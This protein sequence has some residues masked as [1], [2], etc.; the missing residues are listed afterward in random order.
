[1]GKML[2]GSESGSM[3]ISNEGVLYF[4]FRMKL[5]WWPNFLF[6]YAQLNIKNLFRMKLRESLNF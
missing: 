4:G 6:R 2:P 1:M 3:T 5:G